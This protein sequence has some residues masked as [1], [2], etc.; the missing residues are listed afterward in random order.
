MDA[1]EKSNRLAE[2]WRKIENS[3]R[4]AETQCIYVTIPIEMWNPL[5]HIISQ[6]ALRY[7]IEAVAEAIKGK[8]T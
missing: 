1:I 7:S 5:S 2:L 6:C 8:Q 4:S 3:H